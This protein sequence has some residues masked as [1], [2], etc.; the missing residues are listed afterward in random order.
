MINLQRGK[1]DNNLY[2]LYGND[3]DGLPVFVGDLDEMSVYLN[4]KRTN[5]K[6]SIYKGSTRLSGYRYSII[7]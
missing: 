2:V 3:C 6:K 4:R 1:K 5:I 7:E